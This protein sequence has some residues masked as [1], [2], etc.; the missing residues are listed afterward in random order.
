M[1]KRGGTKATRRRAS[2]TN[3]RF[4]TT[5]GARF[6]E[7]Q[8]D[9][10]REAA[11]LRGWSVS[12]L[13]HTAAIEKAAAIV[14]TESDAPGFREAARKLGRCLAPEAP[15]LRCGDAFPVKLGPEPCG[16]RAGARPRAIVS[17][18]PT[19]N[20]LDFYDEAP[21]DPSETEPVFSITLSSTVNWREA[22]ELFEQ[23]R[24]G[25]T[26]FVRILRQTYDDLVKSGQ[27]DP[28]SLVDPQEL[29]GSEV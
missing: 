12:Q 16:G 8:M 27:S 14:N 21:E 20:T 26:D 18:H 13:M 2:P 23:L 7:S 25:G 10:V 22:H 24:K 28:R 29:L 19:T 9:V 4:G 1:T 11:E 5:Q 6:T 17:Y 3:K 15:E